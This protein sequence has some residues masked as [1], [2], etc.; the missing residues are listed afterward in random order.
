MYIIKSETLKNANECLLADIKIKRLL[1]VYS[2]AT[3]K[4][5]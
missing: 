1:T 2:N 5:I 3:T 4:Y